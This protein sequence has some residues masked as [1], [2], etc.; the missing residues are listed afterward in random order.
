MS[1]KHTPE[2]W[3]TDSKAGKETIYSSPYGCVAIIFHNDN[4]HVEEH[5]ANAQRITECVNALSGIENPALYRR[6]LE[7]QNRKLKEAL[8]LA[9]Q[10]LSSIK[11]GHSQHTLKAMVEL[12]EALK[13]YK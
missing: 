12:Q 2:P 11:S 6:E 3:K 9:E 7:V 8:I 13:Q 10:Q 5:R 4:A 1:T